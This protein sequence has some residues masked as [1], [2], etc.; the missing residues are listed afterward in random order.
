MEQIES[1]LEMYEPTDL[2]SYAA[3]YEHEGRI[4]NRSVSDYEWSF[5]PNFPIT[6]FLKSGHEPSYTTSRKGW[7]EWF[8][9]E[10]EMTDNTWDNLVQEKEITIPIVVLYGETGGWHIWDGW[11]RVAS[12]FVVGRKTIPAVVGTPK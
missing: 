10:N 11:H 12:S 5:V 3:E 1:I 9:R 6:E 4:D 8:K 2:E 7:V